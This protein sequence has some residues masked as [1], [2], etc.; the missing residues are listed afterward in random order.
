MRTE[1]VGAL[2]FLASE[3]ALERRQVIEPFFYFGKTLD[4]SHPSVAGEADAVNV[5][6]AP[7]HQFLKYRMGD[8]P[9]PYFILLKI[10]QDI[11][12][13]APK[14]PGAPA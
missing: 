3:R 4:G 6:D 1:V 8:L 9:L 10:A 12:A 14:T 2:L 7:I 11:L 5:F 13:A